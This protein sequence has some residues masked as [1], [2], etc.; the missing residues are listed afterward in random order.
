MYTVDRNQT[1]STAEPQSI[2]KGPR[3]TR[4]IRW[5]RC[6]R[7]AAGVIVFVTSLFGL[8]KMVL[9]VSEAVEQRLEHQH[10]K[11]IQ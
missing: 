7:K 11:H 2:I 3:S 5:V 10:M 8:A 1:P 6:L 9:E 4:R